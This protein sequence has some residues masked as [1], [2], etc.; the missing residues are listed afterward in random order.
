M[1]GQFGAPLTAYEFVPGRA[2][3]CN[4]VGVSSP[5]RCGHDFVLYPWL[6]R[7]VFDLAQP[8][9]TRPV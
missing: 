2:P 4:I 5:N 7:P 1:V 3:G 9:G 6:A 8:V